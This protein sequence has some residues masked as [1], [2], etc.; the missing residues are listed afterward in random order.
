[1][2]TSRLVQELLK[3]KSPVPTAAHPTIAISPAYAAQRDHCTS[4]LASVELQQLGGWDRETV[5]CIDAMQR[6]L[7]NF[8]I[9]ILPN[10]E[11]PRP[12][13]LGGSATSHRR[14]LES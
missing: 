14:L 4:M 3:S 1:M 13:F 7:F 8:D 11:A 12:R 2:T 5:G 9:V 6:K 10:F